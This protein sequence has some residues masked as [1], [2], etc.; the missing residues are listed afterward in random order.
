MSFA[1]IL[2]QKS[3]SAAKKIDE[4]NKRKKEEFEKKKSDRFA[5]LM[6]ALTVKYH[7]Q[8]KKAL[9]DAASNGRREKYM[10]FDYNDFKANFPGLGKPSGI[11]SIWLNHMTRTD[12]PYSPSSPFIKDNKWHISI[13]GKS[14][15]LPNYSLVSLKHSKY[16]L[17]NTHDPND[18]YMLNNYMLQDFVPATSFK[19]DNLAGIK[20]DV[21][22]NAAF[23]VH[24]TW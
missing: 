13:N 20:F 12:S 14:Y 3:I 21:W 16:N 9:W 17:P 15:E 1:E 2:A 4:L 23:T 22:N 24:F 8:I 7:L 10:N 6:T 5:E 19:S 11:C 18:E